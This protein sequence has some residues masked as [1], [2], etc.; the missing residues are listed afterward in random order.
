MKLLLH[1]SIVQFFILFFCPFLDFFQELPAQ[2]IFKTEQICSFREIVIIQQKTWRGNDSSRS[3]VDVIN[4]Y[5]RT[6]AFFFYFDIV[7]LAGSV[8]P[9]KGK[10]WF[11][12]L[13]L[14]EMTRYC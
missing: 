2:I 10:P 6:T 4:S 13:V 1:Q 9:Q 14:P 11:F 5:I 3:E 12:S 8:M 7:D